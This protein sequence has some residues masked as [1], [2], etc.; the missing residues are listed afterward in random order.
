[1]LTIYLCFL[2]GGAVLPFV[3]FIMG[4]L[5]GDMDTD[6]N[7]DIDMDTDFNTDMDCSID[8][9]GSMD[10]DYSFDTDHSFDAIDTPAGTHPVTH[11]HFE[12]NMDTGTDSILSIALIPTSLLAISALAITFGAIG[13]I[14][15]LGNHGRILTFVVAIIIGYL[16]SVFMQTIIKT[17][18]KVQTRNTGVNE[19]EL[20]LYDGKIIDTIL[21]GQMGTVSFVTIDKILVSYPAIC[22]NKDLKLVTGKIVKV[23]EYK[24]GIFIVEPKN[25]YE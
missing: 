24:N 16:V 18:K 11:G 10:T 19:K 22:E 4:S 25:K 1:M 23:K 21:P 6:L 5:S 7:H 17:L 8:T 2:A 14:M 13:A 9:S 3:S 15:T 20:L 12:S